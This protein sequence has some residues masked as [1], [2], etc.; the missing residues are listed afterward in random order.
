MFEEPENPELVTAV[1]VDTDL[2]D[3][4]VNY[5]GAQAEPE[6]GLVTVEMIVNVLSAEFPEFL[7]V[8]AEENWMR[9]YKQ[10]L[11]DAMGEKDE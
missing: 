7:M 5:V 4:L 6:D 10:G 9:G 3:M 1:K 11:D 8:V 2:K